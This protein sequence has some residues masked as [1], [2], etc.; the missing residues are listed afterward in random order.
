MDIINRLNVKTRKEFREWLENNSALEKECWVVAFRGEPQEGRLSYIDAV[1]E[2]ICFGWID[3]TLKKIDGLPYQR[4]SKRV[5]A[6]WTEVNK[7]RAER[8]IRLG[9]MTEAGLQAYKE[10]KEYI[11]DI[12]I[13]NALKEAGV[14]KTF[15][16]FPELYRKAK[17]ST[18]SGYKEKQPLEYKKKLA[19]LIEKTRASK[20]YGEWND[21]GRLD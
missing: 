14:Y 20:M 4:F 17:I 12:D 7:A 6:K 1:E 16:T 9:L 5:N 10:A 19:H 3:S 18:I 11:E 2:A 8:L 13:I 21:Y 15:M